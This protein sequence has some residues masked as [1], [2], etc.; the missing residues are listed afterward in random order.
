MKR[1]TI[2]LEPEMELRLKGAAAR[3]GTTM[4]AVIREALD[5]YLEQPEPELPPGA[6]AFRSGHRDTAT[7]A[8][9]L[10]DDTGFGDGR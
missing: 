5:Q 9:Q 7:R 8:E 2:Y 6:G 1:T 3:R 10:L 4:V